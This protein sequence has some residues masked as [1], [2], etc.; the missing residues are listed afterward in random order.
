MKL[1]KT[2][3]WFG[4]LAVLAVLFGL[5]YFSYSPDGSLETLCAL[6]SSAACEQFNATYQAHTYIGYGMTFC[7]ALLIFS[8]LVAMIIQLERWMSKF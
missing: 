6:G 8:G 1:S 7:V 4:I 3:L 2:V 5:F